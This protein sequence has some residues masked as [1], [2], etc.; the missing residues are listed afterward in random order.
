MFG[1]ALLVTMSSTQFPRVRHVLHR[2]FPCRGLVVFD[3]NSGLQ[4]LR[5]L[6]LLWVTEGLCVPEHPHNIRR[7][8]ATH[9][10]G[11]NTVFQETPSF[12][13]RHE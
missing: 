10:I 9:N 6:R 3:R 2:K 11:S 12:V 7:H 1:K 13:C 8:A 4:V 5:T